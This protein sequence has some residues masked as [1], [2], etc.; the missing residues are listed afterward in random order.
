MVRDCRNGAALAALSHA[1]ADMKSC[2]APIRPRASRSCAPC[3]KNRSLRPP[4]RQRKGLQKMEIGS[5][6]CIVP[7]FRVAEAGEL[8]EVRGR[9]I[10]SQPFPPG[11]AKNG[12]S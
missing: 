3:S 4:D 5:S 12:L 6:Q 11:A 9:Q 10:G 1:W 7:V 2:E 8:V